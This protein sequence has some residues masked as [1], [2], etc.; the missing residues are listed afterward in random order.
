MLDSANK[1]P[2]Y[3]KRNTGFSKVAILIYKEQTFELKAHY[4]GIWD[5][6]NIDL[7]LGSQLARLWF[8]VLCTQYS[9]CSI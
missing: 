7:K 8:L 4:S 9:A 3:G 5:Q 6:N 2:Y 1:A